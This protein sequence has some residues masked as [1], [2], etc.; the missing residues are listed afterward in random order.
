MTVTLLLAL[1][2]GRDRQTPP[3][4]PRSPRSD[5]APAL[6]RNY[7]ATPRRLSRDR[8]RR[9][10]VR[11]AARGCQAF[12]QACAATAWN[13][14]LWN[15]NFGTG[16]LEWELQGIELGTAARTVPPVAATVSAERLHPKAQATAGCTRRGSPPRWWATEDR[17]TK[18]GPTRVAM[19]GVRPPVR[20]I[21]QNAGRIASKAGTQYIDPGR[22]F[23]L[24]ASEFSRRRAGDEP[25]PG[26][27]RS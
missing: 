7:A 22:A 19:R 14:K 9:D 8:R 24:F 21:R 20:C 11:T 13:G 17:S 18:G 27:A 4:T 1:L 25:S 23:I 5:F 3:R 6:V 16:N 12:R 2:H 10:P 15:G 26:S